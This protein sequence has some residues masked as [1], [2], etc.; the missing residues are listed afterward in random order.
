MTQAVPAKTA[1][2]QLADDRR[3]FPGIAWLAT[4]PR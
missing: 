3:E 1:A 4:L 2:Q